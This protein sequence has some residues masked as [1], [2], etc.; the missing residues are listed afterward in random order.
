MRRVIYILLAILICT[1][2]VDDGFAY[3]KAYYDTTEKLLD[4]L[5][6][7]DAKNGI[8]WQD[9]VMEGHE[10]YQ[11]EVIRDKI[12]NLNSNNNE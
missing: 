8:C 5:Y 12:V 10:Y 4:Y 2:C 3:Y 7:F 6:E 11:Y 9:T 1:S